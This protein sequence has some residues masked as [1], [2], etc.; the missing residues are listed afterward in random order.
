MIEFPVAPETPTGPMLA[1]KIDVETYRGTRDG[2]PRL[3]E[4]LK[5]RQAGA[6]FLFSLGPDQTGRALRYLRR[7]HATGRK[8]RRY[9][10]LSRYGFAS[11][12]YGTLL[13][14]PNIGRRCEDT[15]RAVRD[16]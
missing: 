16:A 4:I 10:L 14:S 6:T 3:V 1:L 11:L 9:P 12:L 2:V 8:A 13:P 5:Q 7:R 15:L